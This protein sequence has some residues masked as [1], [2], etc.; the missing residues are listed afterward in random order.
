MTRIITHFMT[1]SK[2]VFGQ[3]WTE[4]YF[5]TKL[6]NYVT[7]TATIVTSDNSY[8]AESSDD[9]NDWTGRNY[10]LR[11]PVSLNNFY[12]EYGKE[13]FTGGV[14]FKTFQERE[15]LVSA[16][17]DIEYQFFPVDATNPLRMK[18]IGVPGLWGKSLLSKIIWKSNTAF[19][20]NRQL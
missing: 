17:Q 2:P 16:L 7:G 1:H 4:I 20:K 18:R 13:N 10:T 12:V 8:D 11:S 6:T 14:G 19:N 9:I 3:E 5:N 15:G